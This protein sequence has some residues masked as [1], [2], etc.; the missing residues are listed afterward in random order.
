MIKKLPKIFNLKDISVL[1][2][3]A[4]QK[5]ILIILLHLGWASGAHASIGNSYSDKGLNNLTSLELSTKPPKIVKAYNITDAST[6]GKSCFPTKGKGVIFQRADGCKGYHHIWRVHN[7]LKMT[8]YDNG[9]ATIVGSVIDNHGKIGHVSVALYDK[10]NHGSTWNAKCYVD[11]ISDPRLLY[12]SFNGTIKV[13]SNSYSIEKKLSEKHFIVADGA[14]FEPGQFGFGAWTGGTFGGCT[15]WFGN[16]TPIDDDCDLTVDAGDDIITCNPEE[17]VLTANVNHAAQCNEIISSYKIIDSNTEKGCFTADPGVIFQKGGNCKGIDYIWRA[18]ENLILN[19]YADD[20]ATISGNVIDQNG[21][22]GIVDIKLTHK[23]HSGN[24]WNA[25]CYLDGISGPETFYRSFYGT[26]TADGIPVTVGTRFNAHYILAQGAGFDNNQYGLGA[27]TGGAFGECTEW[28]GNLVPIEI[29]N[30]TQEVTYLWSTGETTQSI[31]VTEAGEYTVTVTDC[32]GCTV[33]DTVNVEVN[34]VVANA[35]A[36][37]SINVGESTT[38]TATGGGTYIWSTGETT[39]SI[40]VS[41]DETTTYSVMVTSD[42]GEC[43]DA[44]EVIVSV[45]CALEVDLG[46]DLE[47]CEVTETTL[48]ATISNIPVLP[49]IIASYNITDADT[50]TGICAYAHGNEQGVI[51]QRGNPTFPVTGKYNAWKVK[52]ELI[53][54]E[55]DNGTAKINGT[56]IDENGN[57]G[58][59]DMLLFDKQNQGKSWSAKCYE[60]GLVGPR[61]F[62]QSFHGTITVNGVAYTVE[63]KK[64]GHHFVL[65]EGASLEPNQF[66][67]GAWTAG[68]FGHGGEWFGNLEPIEIEDCSDVTYLW[69]TGE[70]TPSI[71]VSEA[72]E[73][74]V[75]IN[76]CNGC[77]ATDEMVIT[78]IEP[79]AYVMEG[80]ADFCIDGEADYLTDNTINISG[81]II[82][83][84]NTFVITDLDGNI[85]GLPATLE[86]VK[87]INF[88]AAG[89]G[90]CLVWNLAFED[91][92]KGAKMGANANDLEGCFKLSNP[93]EVIRNQAPIADAGDD[94]TICAGEEVILTATGGETYL[95]SNGETTASI[96]VDPMSNTIY[97]VTVTSA[98]GCQATDEVEVKVNTKVEADAGDDV[99]I[100]AGEEAMLTATGGET[101]LWSTGE[102]TASITVDPMSNTIYSVTVTSAEGC[103]AIDEVEVKVNAKVEANAGEDVNICFGEEVMLTATGGGSYVW[104]TGEQTSSILVSPIITTTYSVNVV[105]DEGC[106]ATD[107][108]TVTVN[109]VV[110]ADA[111]EDVTICTGEEVKLTATGGETYLWST[112]ETTAS[113]EVAPIDNTVYSVTVTSA[114]G[115]EA[116][117]EVMVNVTEKVVIGDFV[118]LDENRNGLQDDGDT[119]INDIKVTLYNCNGGEVASTRTAENAEGESGAYSFEVC[120]NSGEYYVVFGDIPE[121]TEFT[122]SNSGNEN[123]LDSNANENGRTACFEVNDKDNPTIDGGLVEIC[124]I[125][126]DAGEDVSICSD[127]TIQITAQLL[128]NTEECPSVCVYPIKDQERCSGALGNYEIFLMSTS[129]S[130][131]DAKFKAS[132]QK[133]VRYDDNSARYTATATNGLDE[134]KIDALFT[135]YTTNTPIG[136]PKT[137]Q[138][139]EY[140]TSNWEY[141]TTWTGTVTSENHGVFNLSVMGAAFQMGEGADVMRTGFGASGWFYADGGDG[142]YVSGDVNV[143]VDPCVENGV[144]YKWTTEDG[145][146]V[147]NANQKTIS[148]NEPGTYVVEAI[149]CID[150]FTTDTITVTNADCSDSSKS[151]ITPVIATVFPIPVESGGRLTIEFGLPNSSNDD[152]GFKVASLKATVDFPDRTEDVTMMMYDMTGRVINIPKTFKI[153]NGKAVI[154]L[155]IDYLA[156]GKYILRAQGPN[157][158]N[159]KNILVK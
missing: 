41:P 84:N 99:A 7:E 137:N 15:E 40:T 61:N 93:I 113:I 118:W 78:F 28:F 102:T 136:S 91:G 105:S 104:N 135:G 79:K 33:S 53:L 140:D 126:I 70:T 116:T 127:E 67:F 50:T 122:S 76:A 56:V 51:L 153:V 18:T 94:V 145:N 89:T 71:T 48:T 119:G 77:E 139:Q 74:S 14:G 13:G 31:S 45:D 133:F 19:E 124:N 26:I 75:T 44:D 30:P 138:C 142:F 86:E 12:Q 37:V 6:E 46:E 81:D 62:Y 144:S 158:S 57:I 156:P 72:G 100:C 125:S 42:K 22:I 58:F 27:W 54:N 47:F 85:L 98:E 92:L 110:T 20:T 108:V 146:I 114:E 66:G 151:P 101:Y 95:W 82:G 132:E 17:V 65:A 129:G 36:D 123:D 154:Y 10:Q 29:E 90:T 109:K 59:V 2:W 34:E 38:L 159:A 25:S 9:T 117:D 130:I 55:Y 8:E 120:P 141:W 23:E 149:N 1:K 4:C 60:N 80:G 39:A 52:D 134:I 148:V 69:S 128:E 64:S 97:S 143:T 3:S 32:E 21:R 16:L 112:G 115:C 11:G 147:G 96:T 43:T 152:E 73:Y 68:S 5:G 106:L 111:G 155:D 63:P 24:T 103:E 150:C 107:E 49:S 131:T 83:T 35:G 88:D 87:E 121:G 157:W